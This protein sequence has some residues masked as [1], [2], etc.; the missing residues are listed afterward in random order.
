ME[1]TGKKGEWKKS[2]NALKGIAAIIIANFYHYKN[3]FGEMPGVRYL[4]L[5]GV[6]SNW[7]EY[8]YM[9]GY[10]GVE[11]FFVIAGFIMYYAYYK[12]IHN[13]E[14]IFRDFLRKR[15]ISVCLAQT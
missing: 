15:I 2:V 10:L 4:D 6:P 9:Y 12:K 7:L 14:I 5:K 11:F 13:G 1:S 8:L 3:E